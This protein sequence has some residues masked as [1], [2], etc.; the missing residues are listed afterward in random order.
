MSSPRARRASLPPPDQ[1]ALSSS[2]AEDRRVAD[3]E[4]DARRIRA[5][6]LGGQR[7]SAEITRIRSR[8]TPST[9][10]ATCEAMVLEPWLMSAVW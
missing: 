5:V 10:A 8:R 3:H 9:S 4:G 7:L 6:V 1:D 2:A